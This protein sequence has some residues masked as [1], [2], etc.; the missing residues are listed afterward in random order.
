MARAYEGAK[1]GRRIDDWLTSGA[2]ANT[3]ISGAGSRLRE[4]A[5]DLVR[6][7]PYGSKAV[8]IFVGNAIGTGIIPQARTSSTRLNK[9]IMDAWEL[10]TSVCDFDGDLDFYGMQALVARAMFESGECFIRF[11]DTSFVENS[12]VPFQI[13][14]LE[15]DFL[16]TTKTNLQ[17]GTNYINQ[18]VEFDAKNRRVAYWMW[19]QHPGENA[20]TKI[21]QQSVRVPADQV[22]H[23]FRKSRPGQFR[24]VTAYAPSM[25]RMR[26]LDGY[27]DAELWRKKI[28]ACFAAFVVQNSGAD[29][30]IVGNVVVKNGQGG[31]G[32]PAAPQKVEEFRPGM[33]EY[34][35]PGE[36]VRFGN[37]SSDG[38]YESY[39]RVQLHAIAAGLGI[40]YEQLTGDLSQVNYSSLRAGLL[41][42]RRLIE[43]LR[44]HVFIPKMCNTV[45]RRFID[46]AYIAG[47]I[48][49]QDYAVSWT[50]PKFEMIDPFKDAQAD[51]LMIRNG[52][53]TLKEAIARQGF[54][55][56]KQI[57]EIA[58]TNKLLDDKGIILD[59]DPRYTAKSGTQQQPDQGGTNEKPANV[60]KTKQLELALDGEGEPSA[61]DPA[62][63]A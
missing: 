25:V 24:G 28:E 17:S 23:I 18:G 3:E 47:I 44:W 39:E 52:T 11:R 32:Q 21:S 59:C 37:P 43:T 14:V 63:A 4:R 10:W 8:E 15:S 34:L 54:D 49:K 62:G 9:Q 50:P 57:E 19:P 16:D 56:D 33:I 22:V 42:F 31:S 45:W 6:N 55:P 7:N 29:G 51:T 26:D 46:R 53:M 20:I 35:Q 36:D 1:T 2:S 5:R 41:E 40:T 27:D 61:T 12:V 58:A 13:Q 60:K 30:P 48:S 38:N